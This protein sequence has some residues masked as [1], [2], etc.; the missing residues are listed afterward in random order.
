MS[1]TATTLRSTVAAEMPVHALMTRELTTL[2]RNQT[3]ELA[4][5]LMAL[6]RIRHL[7]V[8]DEGRIVGVV[9]GRDLFRAAFAEALGC[10]S[11]ARR[12]LLRSIGVKEIMSEPAVTVPPDTSARDAARLMLEQ[13]IG[14][15]PVVQG[16][17]LIGLVTETDLLR[18]AYAL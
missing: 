15:L 10:G 9:S 18:C 1:P 17:V 7:P 5:H 2:D 13:R 16:G 4:D 14:C 8:V 6:G 11:K 12:R 3:L